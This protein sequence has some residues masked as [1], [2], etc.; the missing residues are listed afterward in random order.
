MPFCEELRMD[1]SCDEIISS[2]ETVEEFYILLKKTYSNDYEKC[3]QSLFSILEKKDDPKFL[4]YL[5]QFESNALVAREGSLIYLL[6]E[7]AKPAHPYVH[8]KNQTSEADFRDYLQLIKRFLPL[9][10]KEV[11]DCSSYIAP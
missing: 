10:A 7:T 4:I 9:F 1:K 3:K 5:N 6:L 11:L 8:N 2:L